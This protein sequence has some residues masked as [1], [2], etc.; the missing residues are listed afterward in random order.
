MTDGCPGQDKRRPADW[1]GDWRSLAGLWGLPLAAMLAA[2]WLPP[3]GRG[4]VWSV[5]LI[6]M[7]VAC[8][9]NARRCGRTHCRI[10]G[11]FFL[12]MAAAVIG[13]VAGLLPLGDHGWTVLGAVTLV[14]FAAL[15]WGSERLLGR[16]VDDR[17]R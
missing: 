7:G 9:V 10:T 8:L 1:A 15:W 2:I 6:W 4:V 17:P 14:G 3:Y 12:V 11:P 5:T 16:F 13:Y